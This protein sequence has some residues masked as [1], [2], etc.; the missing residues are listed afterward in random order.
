MQSW[1]V[2][3]SCVQRV[4][5]LAEEVSVCTMHLNPSPGVV[6]AP[7]EYAKLEALWRQSPFHLSAPGAQDSAWHI[8]PPQKIF[9]KQRR[10]DWRLK[11]NKKRWIYHQQSEPASRSDWN[12][13]GCGGTKWVRKWAG[14]AA[15]YLLISGMSI[16]EEY[17]YQNISA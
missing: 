12:L 3:D 6:R 5:I 4:W 14:K 1:V 16:S 13:A 15:S 10:T 11:G 8:G 7:G 9:V 2:L 17:T